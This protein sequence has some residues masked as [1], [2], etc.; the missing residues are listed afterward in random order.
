MEMIQDLYTE[1]A[2]QQQMLGQLYISPRGNKYR[3]VQAGGSALVTGNLLQEAVEDTNFR[4]MVVYANAAI[5][6]TQVSVTLGGTAVTANYFDEGHLFVESST[7]IGQA[8]RIKRHT[9]QT[10][11]TGVCTF[12][13]DRPLKIALTTSSQV[14]VRKSAYDGVIQY[15]VTTQTGGAVGVA[16]YAMTASYFGWIQ[17]GGDCP[18]LFDTG[19]NTSNGISGIGPSAAV[20]GSVKPSTGAEGEIIIGYAREVVSVDSTMGMCHLTID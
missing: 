9:V 20:A 14:T 16:L 4:S 19:T 12:T 13:L 6:A 7:G 11:T 15:P 3:Y 18:C 5:G 1:S 10:S 17:S 2:Y 8:F